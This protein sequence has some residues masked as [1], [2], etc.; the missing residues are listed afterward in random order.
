MRKQ[1]NSYQKVKKFKFLV[2]GI[3]FVHTGVLLLGTIDFAQS[4]PSLV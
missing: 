3:D 1:Y 4:R 2:G